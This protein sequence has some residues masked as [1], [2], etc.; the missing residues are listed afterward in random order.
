MG[1]WVCRGRGIYRDKRSGA[2]AD[3]PGLRALL[4]YARDGDVIV[5]HTLD[6]LGRSVGDTLNPIHD[7][8][9]RGIGIGNLADPIRIDSSK[10]DDPVAQLAV[11]MLALF[12]RM[13]RTYVVERAAHAGPA[14]PPTA[15]VSAGPRR[16]RR[17]SRLRRTPSRHRTYHRRHRRQDRHHPNTPLIRT[18]YTWPRPS[19]AAHPALA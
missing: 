5:V 7:L 14:P 3:R 4:D 16:G 18:P 13:E 17:P 10:P 12:A 8:A 2:T 19:D 11:V 1:P 6:R 15:A 9:E